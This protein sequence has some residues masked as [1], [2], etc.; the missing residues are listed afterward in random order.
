M[1]PGGTGDRRAGAAC[2]R[3][4][5]G[6]NLPAPANTPGATA[7]GRG[8][9]CAQVQENERV[10]R[11]PAPARCNL[12][13]H[14]RGRQFCSPPLSAPTGDPVGRP[15]HRL[16]AVLE[17]VSPLRLSK[18]RIARVTILRTRMVRLRPAHRGTPRTPTLFG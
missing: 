5:E 16:R 9:G 8:A 18:P 7:I 3:A 2:S 4:G 11:G 17:K 12:L 14:E 15:E 1:L 10:G 6:V 13:P